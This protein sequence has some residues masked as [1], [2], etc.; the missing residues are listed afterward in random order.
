MRRWNLIERR[1]DRFMRAPPSVRN[2]AG[3]IVVATFA[4]VVGAGV[5]IRVIDSSEYEDVWVGMWW[6]LQ[7][8]TT[9][10]YGDV[11]PTHVSGRLVGAIVMLQGIAFIAIVTAVITS[12]FVARAAREQDKVRAQDELSDREL[13]EK[14]FDELERKLDRLAATLPGSEA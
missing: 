4:V 13:I 12:T 10:G 14:R 6:A 8:V 3:V 1:L 2:A 9:V 5:L 11:T 7:T